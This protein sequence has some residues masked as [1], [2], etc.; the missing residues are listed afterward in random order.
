MI[1][2]NVFG[3]LNMHITLIDAWTCRSER[4]MW[5]SCV[6]LLPCPG[7]SHLVT[8]A[9]DASSLHQPTKLNRLIDWWSDRKLHPRVCSDAH[10]S[11]FSHL[12]GSKRKKV[13][14]NAPLPLGIDLYDSSPQ[15][16]IIQVFHNFGE[17]HC[18]LKRNMQS[19]VQSSVECSHLNL[20]SHSSA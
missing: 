2:G 4:T 15:R 11:N 20:S 19:L 18:N 7:A 12:R 9:K 14:N 13:A 5:P 10:P 17:L 16:F 6:G 3:K 1:G 8:A